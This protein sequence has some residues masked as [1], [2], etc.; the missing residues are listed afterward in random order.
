MNTPSPTANAQDVT[1]AFN[2]GWNAV[3]T[4]W[5]SG[6]HAPYS[7]PHSDEADYVAYRDGFY[8][9]VESCHMLDVA[10]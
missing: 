5:S 6:Y 8:E 4:A 9:A 3:I 10:A 7:N 2:E 1:A